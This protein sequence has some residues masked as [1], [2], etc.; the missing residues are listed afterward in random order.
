V[1]SFRVEFCS[2]D[3]DEADVVR[4]GLETE[5]PQPIRVEAGVGVGGCRRVGGARTHAL[6]G[7]MFFESHGCRYT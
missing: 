4:A 3:S 6:H 5:L 2:V 7:R 1:W